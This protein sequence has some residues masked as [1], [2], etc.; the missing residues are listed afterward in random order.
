MKAI[1]LTVGDEILIGQIINTN[2][3]WMG[4][5]L[6]QVGVEVLQM[7]TI[8][9]KW[10][11]I[12]QGVEYALTHADVV[13][14]TGGLGPTH[15]DIT[16]NAVAQYLGRE[17]VFHQD[18]YDQVGQWFAKRGRVMNALNRSQAMVP[19]G[20]EILPNPKGTACGLWFEADWKGQPKKLA[21]M[22]GV[23]FEMKVIMEESILP[24][25]AK[26][27]SRIIRNKTLLTVGVGESVLAERLGNPA[28]FLPDGVSLA[29]LPSPKFG[30]RLRMTVKGDTEHDVSAQLNDLE[31]HIRGRVGQYIYGEGTQT[32][33][34]V[35]GDL[36][37]LQGKT[38]ACAESCTGGHASDRLTDIAGS[39]AYFMGAIIAYAYEAKEQLLGV[40]H[41]DLMQ[42]GAVSEPIAKQ[43]A[44]GV[45]RV[46]KTDYGLAA[47]GIAG[48]G[49]ATPD[50]P[51][52]TIW[53]AVSSEQ[54]TEAHLLRLFND[55]ILNKEYTTTALLN[56]LRKKLIS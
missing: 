56:L 2:A 20:F 10:E 7:L 24:R 53:I 41:D 52:G 44:E 31:T 19:Q 35:V 11:A 45:R 13:L 8:S 6:H 40:N 34:E 26:G 16:K 48:P 21:M 9:D 37:K 33:E 38:V 23:P 54:G 42:H 29:F 39:S 12:Q 47:T 50:K 32:I 46:M 30:V 15:D 4:E 25:L 36:L 55:R 27:E 49:G 3:A 14:M 51:V 18:L 17:L 5:Q 22:P 43:M 1:L 28:D